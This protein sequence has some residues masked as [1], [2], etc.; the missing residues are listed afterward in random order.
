MKG[1]WPSPDLRLCSCKTV[2]QRCVL[3]CSE[4]VMSLYKQHH[5][6][7]DIAGHNFL[8]FF[9]LFPKILITFCLSFEFH[10][11][12][13]SYAKLVF[14]FFLHRMDML[15]RNQQVDG[16]GFQQPNPCHKKES[17]LTI[18]YC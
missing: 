4:R 6:F 10:M 5:W 1:L 9:F 3:V 13:D 17:K 11:I 8:I 16:Q 12:K 14:I 7:L 18:R 2:F 15:C